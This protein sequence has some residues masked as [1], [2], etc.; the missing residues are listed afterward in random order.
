[1]VDSQMV[2]AKD[3]KTQMEINALM[4]NI[5][6]EIH[7]NFV[8]VSTERL[9]GRQRRIL[10]QVDIACGLDQVWQVL[11]D[12]ESLA[13]FIPNLSKSK[14]LPHPDGGI[15]LEQIGAQCFL[16]IHFCARVV[17]DM[18]ER[19][20]KEVRFSMVEGDFRLFKGTWRLESILMGQ[21]SGTRLYYELFIVPPRIMPTS[22]IEKHFC[23]DLTQNL[24]AICERSLS[25]AIDS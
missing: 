25:L 7:G 20:P 13:D 19:F 3:P 6:K 17:L 9:E 16:N 23:R 24:K 5:S 22:L 11:T 8:R 21:T 14:R 2:Y 18:V 10:A 15:R 1:M 12:Y 4:K